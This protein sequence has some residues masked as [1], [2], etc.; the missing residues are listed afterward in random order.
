M[1]KAIKILSTILSIILIGVLTINYFDDQQNYPGVYTFK[2]KAT[3]EIIKFKIG[4]FP[5]GWSSKYKLVD[6]HNTKE[7]LEMDKPKDLPNHV[8]WDN[9]N[10]K[11]YLDGRIY[12]SEDSCIALIAGEGPPAIE[13]D[14]K[15]VSLALKRL[16]KT[17]KNSK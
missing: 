8:S 12:L 13:E 3:G 9:Y 1:K 11:A 7:L 17:L 15:M 6:S 4:H 14:K 5:N 2:N 10:R 16:A